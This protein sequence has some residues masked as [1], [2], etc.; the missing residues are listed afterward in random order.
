SRRAEF[1]YLPVVR[2]RVCALLAT[3]DF[4]SADS[5]F[6]RDGDP[7]AWLSSWLHHRPADDCIG[8]VWVAGT[9]RRLPKPTGAA[10][11]FTRTEFEA[12]RASECFGPKELV[13]LTGQPLE[14]FATVCILRRLLNERHTWWLCE[15]ANMGVGSNAVRPATPRAQMDIES[16]S[17]H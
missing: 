10:H 17:G 4:V 7:T 12:T 6:I 1:Q 13:T 15:S 14:R 9:Q 8:V 3:V 2:G 11:T 16:R 5:L